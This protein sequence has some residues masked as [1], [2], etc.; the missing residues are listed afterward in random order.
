MV[1]Y[2]GRRGGNQDRF[3]HLS[4]ENKIT[5]YCCITLSCS[6]H[7]VQ[8]TLR[9]II[10]EKLWSSALLILVNARMDFSS[11]YKP[12]YAYNMR[13][14]VLQGDGMPAYLPM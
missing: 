8:A 2:C 9:G 11:Q 4:S 3:C 1:F 5:C 13:S 7:V 6:L 12:K 10:I 14:N